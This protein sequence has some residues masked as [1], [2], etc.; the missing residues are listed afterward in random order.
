M[1]NTDDYDKECTVNNC[2]VHNK[3]RYNIL[4]DHRYSILELTKDEIEEIV[5][6]SKI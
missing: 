1:N 4:Y 6:S 5:K 3:I 2:P